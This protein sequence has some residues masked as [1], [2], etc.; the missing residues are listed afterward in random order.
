MLEAYMKTALKDHNFR[1]SVIVAVDGHTLLKEG[2]GLANIEHEVANTPQT[3]FRIGSVTKSF[4]AMGV[5]LL[6][7]RGKLTVDDPIVRY[8]PNAPNSW[9]E[10][11]I[12]QLLTHTSGLMLPWALPG[13]WDRVM[14]VP[15]TLEETICLFRD[16]P[17]LFGPGE[18][19]Q[20]SGLGYFVLASIIESISAQTY[21]VF[22]QSE[23]LGPLGMNDTGVDQPQRTPPSG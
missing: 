20:Y 3:R 13:F 21:G 11:T 18:D 15:A 19:Y 6:D 14:M 10:I 1:G 2:Y 17:L 8:L 12:H 5:M 23:I 4:T 22:L 9:Q 16:E 7:E